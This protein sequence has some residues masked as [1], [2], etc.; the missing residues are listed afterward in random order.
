MKEHLIKI[1]EWD[2][3]RHLEMTT[4][5]DQ[6]VVAAYKEA[7]KSGDLANGPFPSPDTIFTDVYEEIPWHIKEQMDEIVE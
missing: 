1:G 6:E 5:I 7:V 3:E 4:N 2:E